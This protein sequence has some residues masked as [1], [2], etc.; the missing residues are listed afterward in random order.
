MKQTW[1]TR[2]SQPSNCLRFTEAWKRRDAHDRISR[3]RNDPANPTHNGQVKS[4]HSTSSRPRWTITTR[5]VSSWSGHL[6]SY[7]LCSISKS[8]APGTADSKQSKGKKTIDYEIMQYTCWHQP[9]EGILSTAYT[10]Y[11]QTNCTMCFIN[12]VDLSEPV[13]NDGYLMDSLDQT[14]ILCKRRSWRR[15]VRSNRR[16]LRVCVKY[17]LVQ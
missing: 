17:F 12:L 8:C 1:S 9:Q 5:L 7:T 6:P 10:Q 13:N 16:V 2:P 4:K 15:R 3:K 14:K 11:V